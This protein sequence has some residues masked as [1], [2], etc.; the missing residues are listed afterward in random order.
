MKPGSIKGVYK[1]LYTF[2]AIVE[3]DTKRCARP[4]QEMLPFPDLAI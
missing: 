4:F 2:W 3:L 1:N